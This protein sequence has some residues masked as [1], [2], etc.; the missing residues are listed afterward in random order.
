MLDY[1]FKRCTEINLFFTFALFLISPILGPYIKSMG[2]SNTQMGFIFAV[3]PFSIMIFI[4][5]IGHLSDK[6]GRKSIICMAILAEI[7]AYALYLYDAYLICI[8]IARFLDSIAASTL[9]LITLAKVEDG[10][11]KD[12]GHLSGLFLSLGYIG[13][14]VAPVIGG[15]LADHFFIKF[16]F[17]VSIV[18]M[19][20]LLLCLLKGTHLKQAKIKKSDLNP[21]ADIRTFLSFKDLQAMGLLGICAHATL[22][23]TT[24]FLPIFIIE[25]LNL[26]NTHVGIALFFLG[27]THLLQGYLGRISD[28]I[29]NAKG[30]VTGLSAIGV[31]FCLIY[32]TDSYLSLVL[33]LFL[34]GICGSLWNVSAWTLMSNIGEKVNKEGL[35]VTSYLSIAKIGA[36][37]SYFVSGIIVDNYSFQFLAFLNGIILIAACMISL[38]MF[39]KKYLVGD[40]K[41]A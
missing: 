25:N 5:I 31:L 6:I 11:K 26:S 24:L 15:L 36:L 35:I 14:L 38:L 17:I 3:L 1:N 30:V 20:V 10:I 8:I 39:S 7:I 37:F 28:R 40:H 23:T 18:I 13:R 4:P 32:L 29:G 27:V 41:T 16:P 9:V 12:R 2:Y 33:L 34:I 21:L 22:P 19:A